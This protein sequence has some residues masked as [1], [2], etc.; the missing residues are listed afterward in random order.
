MTPPGPRRRSLERVAD[1]ANHRAAGWLGVLLIALLTALAAMHP[2][3]DPDFGWH[4]ALG[5]YVAEHGS[6]P[7]AEPFTHT[8]R[9]APMVAHEWL[10]QLLLHAGAEAVGLFGLRLLHGAAVALL[11]AGLFVMSRRAGSPPAIALLAVLAYALIARSRFELRPQLINLAMTMALYQFVFMERPALH[12]R[13]LVGIGC[14]VALWANLHAGATLFPVL[15]AVYLSVEAATQFSGLRRPR[16]DDLGRGSLLR[17]LALAA[18]SLVAVLCTPN[19]VRLFPYLLESGRLN[20]GL[21]A[22]WSSIVDFWGDPL[23][24]PL[25]LETLALAGACVIAA[26][27]A[28]ARREAPSQIAVVLFLALL[29]LA[30][31]RFVDLY[32]APL[33]FAA[34]ALGQWWGAPA[35]SA[36]SRQW[37]VVLSA[38]CVALIAPLAIGS[39][40]SGQPLRHWL[41]PQGNFQAVSFPG[42]AVSFLEQARLGGRLFNIERWGGYLLLRTYEQYPI[43][44]DGRWVTLGRKVTRD[45]LTIERRLEGTFEKLDAYGIDILLLPRGWMT[46]EIS[47]EHGWLAAFENFNAGVYL[48]ANDSANLARCREYY[49]A[50]GVSFDPAVG[51]DGRAAASANP[52]WA[53]HLRVEPRHVDHF[54]LW[55]NPIGVSPQRVVDGW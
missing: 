31:Q 1:V 48:R 24:F 4:L 50:R 30:A 29:P 34:A 28:R 41:S 14:A 38:A 39:Q 3:R 27:V 16:A 12:A 52:G 54:R 49:A 6:V 35:R 51:F 17:L 8:A 43:F 33:L 20:R 15:V 19:H 44:I 37:T 45:A 2:I 53:R 55:G 47:R 9:G 11:L 7:T 10:S 18:T 36:T 23:N 42:G 46:G 25:E 13:Q 40:L 32:F 5:R 26:A 21:S 22:E